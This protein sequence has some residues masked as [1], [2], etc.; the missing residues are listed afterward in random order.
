MLDARYF[1]K[2]WTPPGNSGTCSTEVKT[3][4]SF[5]GTVSCKTIDVYFRCARVT[6]TLAGFKPLWSS[7]CGCISA[8]PLRGVK[9]A[10]SAFEL[11]SRIVVLLF[12]VAE[13]K[14]SISMNNGAD[15]PYLI[16]A[17]LPDWFF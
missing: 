14:I 4:L 17:T 12:T 13:D 16:R 11:I 6:A 5:A 9:N 1:P 2:A 15:N 10:F 3:L 7:Y 8:G